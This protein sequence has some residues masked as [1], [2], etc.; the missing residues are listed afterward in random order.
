MEN[1]LCLNKKPIYELKSDITPVFNPTICICNWGQGNIG[2][3]RAKKQDAKQIWIKTT[4]EELIKFIIKYDWKE[5]I[6]NI[7]SPFI[8]IPNFKK[9]IL[10]EFYGVNNGE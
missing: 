4:D 8:N 2:K 3:V 6:K 1:R 10:Q 9:I 5:S 7:S